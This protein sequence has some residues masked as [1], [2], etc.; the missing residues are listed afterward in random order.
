[1][2]VKLALTLLNALYVIADSCRQIIISIVING[3]PIPG[4]EGRHAT[5]YDV[6]MVGGK[7]TSS[8]KEAAGFCGQK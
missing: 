7:G 5:R 2:Y 1:M 3:V 8:R 4:F 6:T